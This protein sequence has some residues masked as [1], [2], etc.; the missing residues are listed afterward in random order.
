MQ[1]L[2]TVS[3][4]LPVRHPAAQT[5]AVMVASYDHPHKHHP[6]RRRYRHRR[7]AALPHT[8]A[9]LQLI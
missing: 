6:H 1:A 4:R 3:N 5:G 2:A 8:L 9:E 7:A